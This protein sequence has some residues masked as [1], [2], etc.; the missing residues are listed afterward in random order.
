M[1]GQPKQALGPQ[2]P[3]PSM[4]SP[5][6]ADVA[7]GPIVCLLDAIQL[8]SHAPA[9]YASMKCPINLIDTR[10]HGH[11]PHPPPHTPLLLLSTA[12]YGGVVAVVAISGPVEAPSPPQHP[13]A[14]YLPTPPPVSAP[15]PPHR[16]LCRRGIRRK[17]AGTAG[18]RRNRCGLQ[19]R[20]H[21]YNHSSNDKE[22]G[23]LFV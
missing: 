14:P 11:T 3:T 13:F 21:D 17:G 8:T 7:T 22:E 6:L 9:A 18:G 4:V 2:D 12:A 5:S 1:T 16:A 19:A 20:A 10:R 23:E 15:W